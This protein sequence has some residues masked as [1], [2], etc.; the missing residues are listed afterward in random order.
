MNSIF[1]VGYM[2]SGKS[3]IGKILAE[4]KNLPFIDIDQ[5]IENQC[6]ITVKK[7]F[8]TKGELY[9]RKLERSV[10]LELLQK[11]TPSIIAL[12]GGTPCYFDN[13]EKIISSPHEVVYL[14]VSIPVLAERLKKEKKQRPLIAHLENDDQLTEFVGKHLF[15][16]NSFY[17]KAKLIID[18]NQMTSEQ[19][20]GAILAKLG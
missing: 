13:M 4:N 19:L 16:R 7:I 11:Q 17:R 20:V 5:Y 3:T 9:F 12:G 15:E 10:L 2:G 14:N 8:E 6:G 18:V 1:L